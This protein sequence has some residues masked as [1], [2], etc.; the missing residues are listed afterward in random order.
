VYYKG[1]GEIRVTRRKREAKRQRVTV[2]TK[3]DNEATFYPFLSCYLFVYEYKIWICNAKI[4]KW[5]VWKL[6]FHPYRI[7]DILI[8]SYNIFK[9]RPSSFQ[10]SN[11][12][13]MPTFLKFDFLIIIFSG[14]YAS[15]LHY[16]YYYFE[17]KIMK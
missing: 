7:I 12:V 4:Y 10:I 6:P 13:L 17:R 2:V 5:I 15:Q 9:Y 1:G 14:F 16:T 11:L 8:L 3:R